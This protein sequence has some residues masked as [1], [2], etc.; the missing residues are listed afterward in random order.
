M[1]AETI[2]YFIPS[3]MFQL[4]PF[5][6]L[7]LVLFSFIFIM[8]SIIC[9]LSGL[10]HSWRIHFQLLQERAKSLKLPTHI[11]IDAG[12]TQIAPSELQSWFLFYLD[13]WLLIKFHFFGSIIFA[14]NS[15]GMVFLCNLNFRKNGN[16][17]VCRIKLTGCR[18]MHLSCS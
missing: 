16:S 7:V 1:L 9:C 14:L 13:W 11:T 6:L 17:W 12:R 15:H 3:L 10:I 4:W 5:I 8:V 2:I 18:K